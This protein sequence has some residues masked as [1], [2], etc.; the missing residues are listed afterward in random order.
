M[1]DLTRVNPLKLGWSFQTPVS[2]HSTGG[3]SCFIMHVESPDAGYE[4]ATDLFLSIELC[5]V[6]HALP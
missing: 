1:A 3:M 4:N 6:S 5:L 2:V